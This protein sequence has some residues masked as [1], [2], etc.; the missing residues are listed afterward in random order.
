ML[1]IVI[2]TRPCAACCRASA[3]SAAPCRDAKM[4]MLSYNLLRS[5]FDT[6]LLL[7]FYAP[8]LRHH[9][10]RHFPP[11]SAPPPCTTEYMETEN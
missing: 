6:P 2:D 1:I 4:L 5:M 7:R 8:S 3:K 11:F 9:A 10:A